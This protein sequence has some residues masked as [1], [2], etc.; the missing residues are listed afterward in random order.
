M[1]YNY[2]GTQVHYRFSKKK[3][4]EVLLLLHGW[5]G[6]IK[7]FDCLKELKSKFRVLELD[8][9]PFGK[10]DEPN[11]W[12]VFS[13][14]NMV[15]SLCEHL[16]LTK[17]HILGHSFG[18]RIGILISAIK[19]SVEVDK[20]VLVDS[21]GLKP[22]RNLSY[23]LKNATY[24]MKKSLG[25]DV[26]NYGSPDYKLLS[27]NMK[28]TFSSIVS[29]HLEEYAKL[30][31]QNTLIIVGEND[32]E[33]PVYM[34]KRLNKLIKNSSLYIMKDTTHFCYLEKPYEFKKLVLNFLRGEL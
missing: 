11:G 12:N 21:A 31:K 22:K 6:N 3:E 7:S 15:I 17:C 33:T 32:T 28:K 10:S 5:Q 8:F 1:L 29:T 2:V 14:A 18:G 20:L 13:Y 25:L 4:G 34:A 24:R 16:K 27:P 19:S 9:P 30:I 23:H 26:S